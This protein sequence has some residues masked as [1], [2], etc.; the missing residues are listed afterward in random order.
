MKEII[1]PTNIEQ[2]AES[3]AKILTKSLNIIEENELSQAKLLL[4][5]NG[6]KVEPPY[7]QPID[8]EICERIKAM[9][10]EVGY[11]ADWNDE[12]IGKYYIVYGNAYRNYTS[13]YSNSTVKSIGVTYTTQSIAKQIVEELNEKR[14]V[15]V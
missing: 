4:E 3:I 14:F 1:N 8:E 11:V 9:N 7:I 10:E 12:S 6:Y 5:Q 2:F 15:R 13:M